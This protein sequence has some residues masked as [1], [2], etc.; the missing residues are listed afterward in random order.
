MTGVCSCWVGSSWQGIT[1]GLQKVVTFV[2]VEIA[3]HF[4]ILSE[5]VCG[6]EVLGN[7]I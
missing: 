4:L 6:D 7:K 3:S 1:V 5:T 2:P